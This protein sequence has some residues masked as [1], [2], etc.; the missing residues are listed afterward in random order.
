[1]GLKVASK[2]SNIVTLLVTFSTDAYPP[3]VSTT[4]SPKISLV[5]YIT[6]TSLITFVPPKN[7]VLI[8]VS[9]T[10]HSIVLFRN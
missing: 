5:C 7:Y 3:V 9:Y 10:F 2:A 8:D 4:A 6:I 1:L